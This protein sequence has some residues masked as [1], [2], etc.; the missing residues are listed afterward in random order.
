[1]ACHVLLHMVLT[2]RCYL[3]EI[4]TNPFTLLKK[5]QYGTSDSVVPLPQYSNLDVSSLRKCISEPVLLEY[6]LY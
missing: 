6:V 4:A 1:M 3:M 2:T 5:S